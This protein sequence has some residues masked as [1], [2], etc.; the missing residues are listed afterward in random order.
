MVG[1]VDKRVS[2]YNVVGVYI[3]VVI[4]KIENNLG[5]GLFFYLGIY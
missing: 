4:M 1:Y 2:Y 5:Y 3:F